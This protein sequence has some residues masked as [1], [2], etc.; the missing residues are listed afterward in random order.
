MSDFSENPLISVVMPVFNREPYL[1][2]TIR[3]ILDQTYTRLEFIPVVDEGSTDRSAS[4]VR[5]STW[6]GRE[7]VRSFAALAEGKEPGRN[8]EA[9]YYIL[10][11]AAGASR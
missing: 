3:S 11:A 5:D 4:I 2:E 8:L 10:S 7:A 9:G 1:A 6:I